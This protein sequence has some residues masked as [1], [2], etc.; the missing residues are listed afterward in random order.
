MKH[1]DAAFFAS[2]SQTDETCRGIRRE[3]QWEATSSQTHLGTAMD[4][5]RAQTPVFRG[6]TEGIDKV[7]QQ[8]LSEDIDA[9][10]RREML[11]KVPTECD[12]VRLQGVSAPRAS[13]WL[14]AVP[15]KV[16][17]N[18]LSNQDLIITIKIWLG[19]EVHD[20]VGFCPFCNM[21]GDPC[22][23][24]SGSCMAGGDVTT[25]HNQIRDENHKLCVRGGLRPEGL[26]HRLGEP[27][28]RGR[29][30]ADVIVTGHWPSNGR[31]TALD[32]AVTMPMQDRYRQAA[33]ER[34]LAA[35]HAYCEAKCAHQNTA[36]LCEAEGINFVPMAA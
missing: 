30:P 6:E 11:N 17:D 12:R 9:K 25:R 31:K 15:S 34:P 3:H 36:R 23:R 8:K 5:L 13:A 19:I 10:Q 16:L 28:A 27:N 2:R 4:R 1:A 29:R 24:H 20:G 26:L 35:A 7:R 21:I 18:H 32:F 14:S 33:A 22:G